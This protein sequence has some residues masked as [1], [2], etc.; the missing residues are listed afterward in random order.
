[1]L[2]HEHRA[3]ASERKKLYDALCSYFVPTLVG[4]AVE[5]PIT[6]WEDSTLRQTLAQGRWLI[7]TQQALDQEHWKVL[8]WPSPQ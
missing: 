1:M 5:I 4:G 6:L 2:V 3:C 7:V 8:E